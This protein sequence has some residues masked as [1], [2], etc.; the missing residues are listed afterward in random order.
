MDDGR[1]RADPIDNDPRA[2]DEQHDSDDIG[3][4]HETARQ[5]HD[6]P[7][8]S[9]RR[10][11]DRVVRAGHDDTSTGRRIIASIVLA[12]GQNPGEEGRNDDRGAKEH[13]RMGNA[14]FH[15]PW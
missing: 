15:Q 12:G 8:R 10:R 9:N 11:G 14:E 2:A 13:D 6:R 1:Q 5:R 4:R 3:R 7:E